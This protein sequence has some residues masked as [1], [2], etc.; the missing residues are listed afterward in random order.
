MIVLGILGWIITGWLLGWFIHYLENKLND[1]YYDMY[2]DEQYAFA[3][4]IFWP[5]SLPV[6]PFFLLCLYVKSC[7]KIW[8][9]KL[10]SNEF[11]H[12]PQTA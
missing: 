4:G 2:W 9:L 10:R 3:M 6:I 8:D 7:R 5:F 12:I 11:G 1:S